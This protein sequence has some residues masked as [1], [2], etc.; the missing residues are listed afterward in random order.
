MITSEKSL[1][2]IICIL[3][4]GSLALTIKDSELSSKFIDLTS[5]GLGGYLA[6][7]IQK[8]KPVNRLTHSK[9]D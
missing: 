3:I 9:D 2:I 6:L 1:T 8:N 7:T 4:V 5:T